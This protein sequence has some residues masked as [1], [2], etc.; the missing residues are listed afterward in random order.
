MPAASDQLATQA[1]KFLGPIAN[2]L[3]FFASKEK[4]RRKKDA[5]DIEK[6]LN[7]PFQ[8]SLQGKKNQKNFFA[9]AIELDRFIEWC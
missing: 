3:H 4:T 5:P 6:I 9:V 7:S 8:F 2:R 1:E